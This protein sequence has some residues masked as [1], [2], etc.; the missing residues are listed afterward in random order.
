[1]TWKACQLS[2]EARAIS[3]SRRTDIPAL[4]AP[5]FLARLRAG[6][7]EYI[8]AGPPRRCRV[9]LAPTEVRWFVFWTRWPRPFREALSLLQRR[10][11]PVLVN[12]T[13]TGLGGSP[14]EPGCPSPTRA[15]EA[16]L[17]LAERLPPG[18]IQW[19][20]DPIF[21]SERYPEA[22]H[23]DAFARLADALAGHVDRVAISRVQAYGRRVRPDLRRYEAEHSDAVIAEQERLSALALELQALAGQRGLELVVCADQPL[24]EGLAARPAGCDSHA[25]AARVYP[26][27]TALRPPRHKPSR[28]G[29]ACCAEVDIGVYDTC[30]M[31]CR[32]SYGSC[33]GATA[34]RRAAAHDPQAPCLIP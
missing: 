34:R 3:A 31:G 2:P 8:P 6:W 30:T 18:A 32:Y 1:M 13:I 19:R 16:A 10:R 25:W 29:C 12:L 27:L 7:A 33:D 9:S 17:E 23:R 14:V 15:L 11:F 26:E 28:P 20:Y 5:W 22:F 24:R 4:Y 21:L